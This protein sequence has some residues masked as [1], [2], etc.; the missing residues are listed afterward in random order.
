MGFQARVN[1]QPA[2]AVAGDFYG[3][4]PRASVTAPPGGYTAAPDL[5]AVFGG[6]ALAALIVGRFAWAN[7][8]TGLMANYFQ[9]A[10]LLGFV[11]RE[12][13]AV[14]VDY[15]G[16]KRFSY[17]QG[18]V[19]NALSQGDVYADFAPGPAVAGK[20]VYADP[21]TGVA[22]VNV[23]GQSVKVTAFQGAIVAATGVLTLSAGGAGAA[24]GQVVTGAG[25]APGT[26]ITAQLTGGAGGNGT[27]QTNQ[28]QAANVVAEAVT[29]WGVQETNWSLAS[30]VAA[31]VAITGQFVG[32]AGSPDGLLTVTAFDGPITYGMRLAGVGLPAFAQ[33][34][35]QVSGAP[36]GNGV[37]VSNVFIVQGATEAMTLSQ[38][39]LGKISTWQK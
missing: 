16:E 13:Q 4:N 9:P 33:V 21:V 20:K 28:T 30:Q 37:Y 29:L 8:A 36:G 19:A 6:A 10:S 5:P 15:L 38:G 24:V 18:F 35:G 32:S 12:N 25:I 17:N 3:T 22:T 26:F 39:T 27:Y 7:Y 34:F 23:T 31:P 14:I 1:Q 2:P 11:H